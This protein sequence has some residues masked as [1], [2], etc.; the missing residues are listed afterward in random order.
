M[1]LDPWHVFSSPQQHSD[2]ICGVCNC[3]VSLD[4][5]VVGSCSHVLCKECCDSPLTMGK[6]PQCN[7]DAGEIRL[8]EIAQ[9]L[10]HRILGKIKVACP[11]RKSV[12]ADH[13]S[14]ND[15]TNNHNGGGCLWMGDY[16][17]LA[18]HLESAHGIPRGDINAI[19]SRKAATQSDE[20]K[21]ALTC[22]G[23][24]TVED[25]TAVPEATSSKIKS[26][27][28]NVIT[29]P[30]KQPFFTRRDSMRN[31]NTKPK[32]NNIN[33]GNH[34]SSL[35]RTPPFKLL[36]KN[37]S[38]N[39]DNTTKSCSSNSAL[40]IKRRNLSKSKKDS[41]VPA[42]LTLT[43]AKSFTDLASYDMNTRRG[44]I[45]HSGQENYRNHGGKNCVDRVHDDTEK[46]RYARI[47]NT[48]KK[49]MRRRSTM[50]NSAIY[51]TQKQQ[52][53]LEKNS[54]SMTVASSFLNS[55]PLESYAQGNIVRKNDTDKCNSAVVPYQRKLSPVVFES[56]GNIVR[57]NDTAKCGPAAMPYQRKLSPVGFE[58]QGNIA[59][60]NITD[61]CGPAVI[62]YQRK[63]S[64][65][66]VEMVPSSE[67]EFSNFPR[68]RRK[69]TTE[70]EAAGQQEREIVEDDDKILNRQSASSKWRRYRTKSKSSEN[71]NDLYERRRTDRSVVESQQKSHVRE[72]TL[73]QRSMMAARNHGGQQQYLE[74]NY[75]KQQQYEENHIPN[76]ENEQQRINPA[77]IQ[78]SNTIPNNG[79]QNTY[80]QQRNYAAPQPMPD[81]TANGGSGGS[82]ERRPS[83]SSF[84]SRVLPTEPLQHQQS[85]RRDT[86]QLDNN[87]RKYSMGRTR[88]NLNNNK[89]RQRS[90]S[91]NM[92][93]QG[94]RKI[95]GGGKHLETYYQRGEVGNNNI[96]DNNQNDYL[97]RD[98][99]SHTEPITKKV[100][101]QFLKEDFPSY[102]REL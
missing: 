32:L 52:L 18:Y 42:K 63:L 81:S 21:S 74:H 58:L 36:K 53:D 100:V 94:P 72:S 41:E 64:P 39:N 79:A 88:S 70:Q 55:S 61:K 49:P 11:L 44:R 47:I 84:P 3:L 99:K 75:N 13:H 60:K 57:K 80:H 25:Q 31:N 76:H 87:G 26:N 59:R 102:R 48:K 4:S 5:L 51:S 6:C 17:S 93:R 14:C 27:N 7:I 20:Q 38:N 97:V 78:N 40:T 62:S 23:G 85:N 83:L 24:R 9:P 86:Q 73:G 96:K 15:N 68:D 82:G 66:G 12:N 95:S 8:L 90:C 91:P 65:V 98:Y 56:Q 10:A 1:G 28:N 37:L 30:F 43:P 46:E 89:S 77:S 67:S 50:D 92:E 71:R 29:S 34:R 22:S 16:Q 2:L 69:L 45:P 35:F 54:A 101:S 33:A 19:T